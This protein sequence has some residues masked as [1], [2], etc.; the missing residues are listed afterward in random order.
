MS[1]IRRLLFNWFGVFLGLFIVAFGAYIAI[2]EPAWVVDPLR[3][4]AS[5]VLGGMGVA[6]V[7][8]ILWSAWAVWL[9]SRGYR[10]FLAQWR[11]LIGL[12]FLV[13][14][15]FAVLSYFQTSFPLIGRAPL[16]GEVGE[17]LR[18]AGGVLGVV[19]TSVIVIVGAWFLAPVLFATLLRGTGRSSMR[20]Q[21]AIARMISERRQPSVETELS[22]IFSQRPAP[23]VSP[24]TLSPD[25]QAGMAAFA[26]NA[27]VTPS[28]GSSLNGN[29]LNGALS[30]SPARQVRSSGLAYLE[31]VAP[32]AA[33]PRVQPVAARPTDEHR[34]PL[35]PGL[36]IDPPEPEEAPTDEQ[37]V[38]SDGA[39]P[40]GDPDMEAS[41]AEAMASVL[42]V[43]PGTGAP[44]L[45]TAS[46]PISVAP[47]ESA[48]PEVCTDD[49]TEPLPA[50]S[51]AAPEA[52]SRP[53][54]G[55]LGEMHMP[56]DDR[57]PT[58]DPVQI[59][60][61]HFELPDLS[62]LAPVVSPAAITQEHLWAAAT[63]E[64][65]L[66]DHGVEVSVSEIR[67]G[68]S[69]TMFGLV[70]G[71]NRKAM[72]ARARA[73][74]EQEAREVQLEVRNRVKVDSIL[75]REKDLALALAAPSLRIQ[76]PV[77]GESVV[78]VEVPNKT[79]SMVTIRTVMESPEYDKMVA[80]G[81]LPVALGLASAGEP[82]VIDLTK[83]PHLLIAGATGSGKSV[84]INTI[85]SSIIT[86]QDPAKVRMVLVD[87]KRVELTPYNGIPHLVTPVVVDPDKVVRLL[88]GAIEEMM[89]RYKLLEEAGAR[90]ILSYNQ[91]A[92][93]VEK[94]P[95]FVI[96]IDEL[97]DLMMTASFD[98][99]QS[100]CRLAQLGR[101]TGIH[102][103]VATQRPSVNV[104]TGLIKANFPSRIAFAVPSQIDSRTIIDAAGAERLLGRGDM[105][106]LSSDAP[107]PRRVQGVFISEDETAALSE[108]WRQLPIEVD[109]PVVPLEELAR[110]AEVAAAEST[111]ESADFDE[112]DSL[113]DRALQLATSTR[114]LST[115]LLQRRL[116]IG[117]P[118]AARLMDQLEE[119]GIVAGT[120]EPGKPR[121][122][123]YLPSDE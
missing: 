25:L 91:S 98:V 30:S 85:I 23:E 119:E 93:T 78:G 102:L 50:A 39:F 104:L 35:W 14:G 4:A 45:A 38:A 86:H 90:N 62:L 111:V 27:S 88:R 107:K 3:G 61:I 118:R 77:P 29:S 12:G 24:S 79:S 67:P 92:R 6:I 103:I 9:L 56:A 44:F 1:L 40:V 75:A 16:G 63:I 121:E 69:V 97:A 81:G 110:E 74:A 76:A 22:N 42:D 51:D 117:Y 60:P 101:A 7:L 73:L 123:I 116:R 99:E 84:C 115:S 109:L 31:P 55:D 17:Q 70:P 66:A 108:H 34:P 68:P 10:R 52:V 13:G 48:W 80:D 41:V 20:A 58:L 43:L 19:R 33:S 18:G 94:M 26:A 120:S 96:C 112:T 15:A 37:D 57:S 28:F 2:A 21:R 113:Y 114:Q 47:A 105:L 46:A 32:R 65:T 8:L 87:P 106:F 49:D 59:E 5:D 11:Y 82:V 36:V 122:V 71:W 64:E 95:Y 83:M 72:S 54:M 100:L 89:R 53:Y